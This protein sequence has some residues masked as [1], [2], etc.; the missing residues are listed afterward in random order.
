MFSF[1]ESPL[2]TGTDPTKPLDFVKVDSIKYTIS[3]PK[4]HSVVLVNKLWNSIATKILW[5]N[6]KIGSEKGLK[7]FARTLGDEVPVQNR[8]IGRKKQ[9][10]CWGPRPM[11]CRLHMVTEVNFV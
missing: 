11:E 3:R 7:K 10:A 8:I 6:I 2:N 9:T 5:K 1:L 4:L